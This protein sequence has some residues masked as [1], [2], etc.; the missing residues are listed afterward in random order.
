M[1]QMS[2]RRRGWG[3]WCGLGALSL[4]ALLPVTAQTPRPEIGGNPPMPR[5][6]NRGAVA[7]TRVQV[8]AQNLEIPWALAFAPDGRIF[9]TERPGRVRVMR[10]GERPGLYKDLSQV[11]HNGEGGLMGMALHPQFPEQPYVYVHYTRKVGEQS[12]NRVTRFR[13]TG[14]TMVDEEVI[15]DN[16]PA[17]QFHDGGAL[18]FGPEGMLYVGTGDAR[19]PGSAQQWSSL[20]GKILRVA[21]DGRIPADNPFPGS[22][23][24]AY[25]FRN[26]SGL[27]WNPVNGELWATSHGPTGEFTGLQNRDS[28]YIVQKGGNH[29]WPLVVG[30]SSNPN[31]VSPVLYYPTSAVPP[32]GAMFYTGDRFPKWKNMFFFTSLRAEHVQ[33]VTIGP[34]NTIQTIERWF[35][36]RYGRLRAIAQAP[37]GSIYFTTSNRDDR[38]RRRFPGAD[39]IYR[40]TTLRN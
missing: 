15:I 38:A 10:L 5:P 19:V 31:I 35:T 29:G 32:G 7:G 33:R 20:A 4:L 3:A 34:K 30:T 37:D 25:G 11:T 24:W 22:P 27:A 18:A 39:R 26:V 28:V 2:S 36:N 12:F 21:P 40:L 6:R 17:S 16:I 13:D 9:F 8:V 14:T 23:V 1:P